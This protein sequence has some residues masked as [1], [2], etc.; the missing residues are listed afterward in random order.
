MS[1]DRTPETQPG[2]RS[3][4]LRCSNPPYLVKAAPSGRRA[5][6]SI[7]AAASAARGMR[8]AGRSPRGARREAA[9]GRRGSRYEA[10]NIPSGCT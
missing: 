3:R 9:G 10:V 6:L 5:A 1:R 2:S 8:P 7:C 4:S